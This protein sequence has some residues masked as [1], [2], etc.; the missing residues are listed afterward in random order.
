MV[1]ARMAPRYAG[2]GVYGIQEMHSSFADK[3]P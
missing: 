3:P 1:G 2:G